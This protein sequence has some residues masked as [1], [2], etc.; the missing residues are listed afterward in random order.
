MKTFNITAQIYHGADRY[1]QT[2]LMNDIVCSTNQESAVDFFK[3]N[4]IERNDILVKILSIET[5]SQD[6]T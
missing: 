3:L 2:I 1:R 4:L 6:A 5:I